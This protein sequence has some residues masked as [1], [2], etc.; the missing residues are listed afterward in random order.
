[1]ESENP[2]QSPK[3]DFSP[4]A[5]ADKRT[6]GKDPNWRYWA[7]IATPIPGLVWLTLLVLNLRHDPFVGLP[8]AYFWMVVTL[9]GSILFV[10]ACALIYIHWQSASD[11]AEIVIAAVAVAAILATPAVIIGACLTTF[12]LVA[13]TRDLNASLLFSGV[14]AL[15]SLI[16]TVWLA[17]GIWRDAIGRPKKPR[18]AQGDPMPD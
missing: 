16:F 14:A 5:P 12:T 4:P 6:L 17:H 18:N 1:M 15:S 10:A 7:F 2:Y 3:S 9:G 11:R 13:T 8:V